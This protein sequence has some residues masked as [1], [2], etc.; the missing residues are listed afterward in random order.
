MIIE[1]IRLEEDSK[2]IQ[3]VIQ[4]SQDMYWRRRKA[5]YRGLLRGMRS[6][7]WRHSES[8][9]LSE[10]GITFCPQM[11][12]CSSGWYCY[13]TSSR[14][15]RK[16]ADQNWISFGSSEAFYIFSLQHWPTDIELEI[17]V[18]DKDIH[19]DDFVD[20]FEHNLNQYSPTTGRNPHRKHMVRLRGYRST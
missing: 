2:R 4:R 9:S 16:Y 12:I 18:I 13:Y 6:D 1:E 10:L 17:R 15:T 19:F 7:T 3:K 11:Q 14:T 20:L 8:A 5:Y